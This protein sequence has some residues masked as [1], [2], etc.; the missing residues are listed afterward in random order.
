[1]RN[2]HKY[3]RNILFTILSLPLGGVGGGC[4]LGV[5]GGF[6]SSCSQDALTDGFVAEADSI[7]IRMSVEPFVGEG[8]T[9]TSV[10]GEAFEGGEKIR[11]K[12]ICPHS[13]YHENGET[14]SSAYHEMTVPSDQNMSAW[15]TGTIGAYESQATTY[16]YS[17]Q[18]TTGT[19]IFVVGDWRYTRPSN[20]FYADQS[21]LEHFK[22]S[23]VVWAQA[24]R[25]TGAREVHFNFKH[26]VAKLDLTIDDGGILSDNAILT[27]EGMPDIDGAEIVVGDY[28]ADNCYEEYGYNYKQKASCSYE[29][30]GK[31]IGIEVIDEEKKKS[32]VYGMTGN[33]SPAGTYNNTSSGTVPNTGTYTAYQDPNNKKHYLLYVPV[34]DLDP[35]NQG[36]HATFWIRDKEKR[37]SVPLELKKF[38]EGVWYK[39]K[40][41]IN[42]NNE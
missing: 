36:N 8:V 6:L 2:I 42:S 13:N 23:D 5:G 32:V 26:K 41:K 16:V 31:V 22:K 1:M 7:L 38:E 4:F 21:K 3:I 19:R 14:W 24:I 10:T 37:Y 28:Y 12:V 27:L 9:R 20:F 30:N 35:N 17:A 33:P 15:V 18:N 39:Q 29:N 34:C 25:Q 11:F 40:I